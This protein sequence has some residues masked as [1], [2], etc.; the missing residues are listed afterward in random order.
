LK[1]KI[2]KTIFKA[3]TAIKILDLYYK[4]LEKFTKFIIW[5]TKILLKYGVEIF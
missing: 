1:Y 4:P 2:F 3:I 5:K